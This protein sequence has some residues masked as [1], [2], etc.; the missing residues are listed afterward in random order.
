[1]LV[2]GGL[3]GGG[4]LASAELYDPATGQWT[5]AGAMIT[6]RFNH[7]ATLMRS[8]Q[9]LVAGGDGGDSLASAELYS[10]TTRQ[11]TAA[12]AMITAR[13]FHTATL[14]P[15]EDVVVVAGGL[16]LEPPPVGPLP[17]NELYADTADMWFGYGAMITARFNH[18]ATLLP[19]GE[20]LVAGGDTGSGLLAGAEIVFASACGSPSPPVPIGAMATARDHH[21]AT[22]LPTGQVLVAGGVEVGGIL[23]S[24]ELYDP[25]TGQWTAAGTMITARINHT[26]TLLRTGQVLVAGGDGGNNF[27]A[28]AELY[29]GLPPL[30]ADFTATQIDDTALFGFTDPT[31]PAVF[32]GGLP[33]DLAPLDPS[34]ALDLVPLDTSGAWLGF[35]HNLAPQTASFFATTPLVV[36]DRGQYQA[37][38]GVRRPDG[39]LANFFLRD[40]AF[41]LQYT[42]TAAAP[43]PA[44]VTVLFRFFPDGT[45]LG[46]L[47]EGEVALFPQCNYQGPAAVFAL[48][49]PNLAALSSSVVRLDQIGS[50]KLGNNTGMVLYPEAG[51]QGTG[52]IVE[53]DTPCLTTP[54]ASFQVKP[55]AP[56][57]L[58]SSKACQKC[59]LEGIDLSGYDLSGYDLS[60][61]VLQGAILDFA[62]LDGANLLGAHLN[63]SPITLAAASLEGAFL[64]NANL[65]Q[66]DLSGAILTDAN[67]YSTLCVGSG[68]CQCPPA[69]WSPAR[70]TCASAVGA[71]MTGTIFGGAYLS[72]V[73][74]SSATPQG[75]QFGGAVLVGVNFT[76]ANLSEDPNGTRTAFTGAFLQGVNFDNADVADADFTS[77]YVD[78][79]SAEGATMAFLLG[80]SHTKFTGYWQTPGT[81]PCLQVTYNASTTLPSIASGNI[82]PD[83]HLGQGS[84]GACTPTQWQSPSTPISQAQPPSS[85]CQ[86]AGCQC[87][88][89]GS[90]IPVDL[91]WLFKFD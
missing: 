21:T 19:S 30:L 64:R 54:A 70:P 72:G 56:T 78:V 11:W 87:T 47:Q 57:L 12:R 41:L 51:Y 58:V 50:I 7:T 67:F 1:V 82:C 17:N 52:Q 38:L 5:A 3:G 48:D 22:L 81:P 76:G 10:P 91:Q 61:A 13:D 83:G 31:Q 65:A 35:A 53:A 75:A 69:G 37:Y 62:D 44:S 23:A 85:V 25:A 77:A 89:D 79:T 68:G 88:L 43:A 26:A 18:T 16:A 90:A 59:R 42:G 49:T 33:L 29:E 63:K 32:A 60:G 66:A 34:G 46:A 86:P 39:T 2:A 9:V 40:T 14:S 27:L 24:A 6:A 15:C 74:L 71:T 20:V 8:G 84:N 28:S 45:Q 80:S 4:S 55:L 36:T 73:D